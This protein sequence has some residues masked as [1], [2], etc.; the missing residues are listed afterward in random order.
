MAH[1]NS[2]TRESG[3]FVTEKVERDSKIV[4]KREGSLVH[5]NSFGFRV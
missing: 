1:Y 3:T 2:F 5:I 4:G